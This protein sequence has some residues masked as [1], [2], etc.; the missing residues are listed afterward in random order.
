MTPRPTESSE[1][2]FEPA[3]ALAREGQFAPA[4]AWVERALV[5]RPELEAAVPAAQ[6][7]ARIGRLAEGAGDL[8]RAERALEWALRLRPEYAD[9]NL[10]YASILIARHRPAEARRALERALEVHPRYL[11]ARI[12]LALLDAREGRIGE[13]LAALREV[14]RDSRIEEPRAFLRGMRCLEQADCEEA[15]AF[16]RRALR[17]ADPHLELQLDRVGTLLDGGEFERAAQMLRGTLQHFPGYP[18]LHALLASAEF[19]LGA[20]DDAI[21]SLVRALELNPD[22][23]AARVQ[24][25]RALDALGERAQALDQVAL[26]LEQDPENVQAR[27]LHESW[28]ARGRAGSGRRIGARKA[29]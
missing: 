9:F 10:R 2:D 22:F 21:A 26:A 5:E 29:S 20:F 16:L 23:T 8:E 1:P 13:A 6:A 15:G 25:A 14:Q 7:L 27:E 11:S 3:L 4:L 28:S 12:E 19:R 24:L 17:G 18:D